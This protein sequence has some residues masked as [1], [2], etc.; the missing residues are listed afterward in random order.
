MLTLGYAQR[1]TTADP[2][3]T[4]E[5][6]AELFRVTPRTVQRWTKAGKLR[7]LRSSDVDKL[8]DPANDQTPQAAAR[9]ARQP[10]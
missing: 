7:S 9:Y 5:Q 2:T 6:V 8:L 3:L 1:R 10:K 4:R